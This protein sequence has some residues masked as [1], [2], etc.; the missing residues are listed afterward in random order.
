MSLGSGSL[1]LT[2]A[3][4]RGYAPSETQGEQAGEPDELAQ[5]FIGGSWNRPF[6]TPVF[7]P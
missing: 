2:A 6:A 5:F 4:A 7:P 1:A 3:A